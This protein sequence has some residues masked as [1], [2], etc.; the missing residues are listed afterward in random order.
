MG[1]GEIEWG[2]FEL[3]KGVFHGKRV[4][5]SAAWWQWE[6]VRFWVV[7]E[8]GGDLERG[9]A[10]VCEGFREV[11]VGRFVGGR[12]P[13]R[14]AP[15]ASGVEGRIGW[16]GC[17][18]SFFIVLKL[19]GGN[20]LY[21]TE[22]RF[23][24]VESEED[25]KWRDC[26]NTMSCRDANIWGIKSSRKLLGPRGNSPLHPISNFIPPSDRMNKGFSLL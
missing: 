3:A 23:D 14:D 6:G 13:T 12:P 16:W 21:P 26:A 15:T 20:Y 9:R 25:P 10:A 19:A 8:S 11:D 18:S 7:W 17:C 24:I 4:A 5:R 22:N 2:D 1:D